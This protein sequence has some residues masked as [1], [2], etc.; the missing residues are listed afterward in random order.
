H[1]QDLAR[2]TLAGSR[3]IALPLKH[4]YG[5]PQINLR[6]VGHRLGLSP[7]SHATIPFCPLF[8]QQECKIAKGAGR[9]SERGAQPLWAAASIGWAALA[10]GAAP[11]CGPELEFDRRRHRRA[12]CKLKWR[13]ALRSGEPRR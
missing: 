2:G 12:L 5:L 7:P 3:L 1:A 6:V 9:R 11:L 4:G 8:C 10:G 13:P